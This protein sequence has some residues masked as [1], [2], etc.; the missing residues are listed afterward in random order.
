MVQH[1]WPAP[2]THLCAPRRQHLLEGSHLLRR[3]CQAR[4]VQRAGH[5]AAGDG[6]Q[7]RAGCRRRRCAVCGAGGTARGGATGE[8]QVGCLQAGSR[9]AVNVEEGEVTWPGN[10]HQVCRQ[11]AE[12]PSQLAALQPPRARPFG[13]LLLLT[14][15][16]ATTLLNRMRM[17]VDTYLKEIRCASGLHAKVMAR[18]SARCISAWQVKIPWRRHAQLMKPGRAQLQE[19][20]SDAHSAAIQLTRAHSWQAA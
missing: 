14:Q 11:A 1:N 9:R 10:E 8:G 13:A 5:L 18:A 4:V 17:S 6:R 19:H 3:F 2:P 12:A 15:P 7:Q 16:R 20:C